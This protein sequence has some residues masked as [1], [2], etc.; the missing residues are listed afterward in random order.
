[1]EAVMEGREY[2]RLFERL[3]LLNGMPTC[4]KW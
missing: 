4:F 2:S 1:M 3:G